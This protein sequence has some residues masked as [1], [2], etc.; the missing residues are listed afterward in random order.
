MNSAS[1]ATQPCWLSR[2]LCQRAAH[3]SVSLSILIQCTIDHVQASHDESKMSAETGQTFVQVNDN[4]LQ[5]CVYLLQFISTSELYN[6]CLHSISHL[7][8]N[9][10]LAFSN[11][12]CIV[13][14]VIYIHNVL[15]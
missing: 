12:L 4:S 10:L 6:R 5:C 9:F 1:D 3:S 8:G 7:S 2:V 13:N 14:M 11:L 15:I